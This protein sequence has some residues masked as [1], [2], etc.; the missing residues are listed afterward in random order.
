MLWADHL[1]QADCTH[2]DAAAD[3]LP[4]SHCYCLSGHDT[5]HVGQASKPVQQDEHV[6]MH[7][8]GAHHQELGSTACLQELGLGARQQCA[9][10]ALAAAQMQGQQTAQAAVVE[11]RCCLMQLLPAVLWWTL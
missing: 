1:A 6:Q 10:A 5:V 7:A 11:Q 8:E 4:A 2:A 9:A 3:D